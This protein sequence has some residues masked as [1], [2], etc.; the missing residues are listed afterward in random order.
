MEEELTNMQKSNAIYAFLMEFH[1]MSYLHIN[2]FPPQF[3]GLTDKD[4]LL[5]AMLYGQL[6]FGDSLLI[7]RQGHLNRYQQEFSELYYDLSA[8]AK[9]R[10]LQ[11]IHQAEELVRQRWAMG[12]SRHRRRRMHRVKSRRSVRKATKARKTRRS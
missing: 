11:L 4:K 10:Y 1:P 3:R 12:G 7:F 9:E 6:N 5:I 2:D 8:D